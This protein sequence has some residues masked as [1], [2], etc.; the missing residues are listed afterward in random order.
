MA[1]CRAQRLGPVRGRA[2]RHVCAAGGI[3]DV[4]T[5]RYQPSILDDGSERAA[6]GEEVGQEE[7]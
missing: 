2:G 5:G 3:V 6:Y 1:S 7:V 4:F